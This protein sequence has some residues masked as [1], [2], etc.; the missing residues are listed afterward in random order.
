[1]TILVPKA[2]VVDALAEE[3]GAIDDL[4]A[5]LDEAE[6][7]APTPCPGWDV[8]ANVAHIIGTESML[9]GIPSPDIDIEPDAVP[10]V[11]N[12]I[13]RFN[14]VW[15]V[16]LADT[17]PLEL[18]ARLRS[19]T[20]QRLDA[21]R[22]MDQAAWDEEGFTPAGPDS[23]GRFMRIR[24][25]DCWMHEQDIRDGVGRPGHDSGRVVD[26]V[27]DEMTSALGF[28]V[29]KRAGAPTGSSVTFELTGGSGRHVHVAVGERGAV[30]PALDGP[31]TVTLR[32]PVGIFTRLAG[33]RV[34][35]SD[36]AHQVGVSG[37]ETLGRAV[38]DHLGYTI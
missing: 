32:M 24:V 18:R 22:D 16:A 12:D 37:D 28:V 33:G 14:E 11:R 5:T 13:G 8:R 6:W 7:S 9:A 15:V 30:V 26:V 27:L 38:L 23:Y 19:I 2:P 36:V 21:L 1:V 4:L 17:P 31:P 34:R 29:G 10:H 3:F 25:F 35:A 20:G